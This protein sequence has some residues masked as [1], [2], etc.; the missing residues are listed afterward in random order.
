MLDRLAM[1]ELRI[2]S[3]PRRP[4]LLGAVCGAHGFTVLRQLIDRERMPDTRRQLVGA[5]GQTRQA[6]TPDACRSHAATRM[7]SA[8]RG[9]LPASQRGPARSLMTAIINADASDV[10]HSAPFRVWRG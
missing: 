3:S 6:G 10:V 7:Q 1:S 8:R 5:L 2:R 9:R 4:I